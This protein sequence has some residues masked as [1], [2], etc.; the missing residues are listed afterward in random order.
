MFEQGGEE[1]DLALGSQ[2]VDPART[3]DGTTRARR[4]LDEL[5][6][7]FKDSL[8]KRQRD[9]LGALRSMNSYADGARAC[10]ID[11]AEFRRVRESL[12][13]KFK[14]LL[15]TRPPLPSFK[16]GDPV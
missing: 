7:E 10:G 12:I 8:T 6:T 11:K 5:M 1:Q 15:K 14:K 16:E 13:E 9:V 4:W 3:Y 2:S